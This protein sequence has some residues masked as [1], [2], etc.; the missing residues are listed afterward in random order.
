MPT[1]SESS[2]FRHV[3]SYRSVTL[4]KNC[5]MVMG[6]RYLLDGV[7]GERYLME[8]KEV[9]GERYLM[10]ILRSNLM[11]EVK[12]GLCSYLIQEGKGER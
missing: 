2:Q 5:G 3:Y 11:E 10:E 7:K 8:E 6:E 4:S 1:M 9:K 12:G